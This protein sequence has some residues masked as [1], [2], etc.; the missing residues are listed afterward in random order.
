MFL[1][2]YNEQKSKNTEKF[3]KSTFPE[4]ASQFQSNLVQIILK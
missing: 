4:P 2:Q 1:Q 3:L